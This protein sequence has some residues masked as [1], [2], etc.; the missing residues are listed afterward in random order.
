MLET[1]GFW[2]SD[3]DYL[4]G[5]TAVTELE[6]CLMA[7]C[8]DVLLQQ[9][10]ALY[11]LVNTAV[12]GVAYATTSTDP[13]IVE[14]AIAPHVTTDIH[15]YESIMGKLENMLQLVDNSLN[16]TAT[17]HYDNP[18]SVRDK[19]QEVIDALSTEDTDL[20]SILTQLEL[21]AAAVA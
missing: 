4:R 8:L 13:L 20:G 18:P 6:E 12:Y 7:T 14:P 1:R 5:Y 16:G 21:I 11:R 2:L 3:A 9:N 17:P 10:D 19:L 15:D